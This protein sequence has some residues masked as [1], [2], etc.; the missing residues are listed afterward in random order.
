MVLSTVKVH[1]VLVVPDSQVGVLRI[2]NAS[3]SSPLDNIKLKKTGFH[4]LHVLHSPPA[5]KGM[6]GNLF[7]YSFR[8]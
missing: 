5:K 1:L 7:F 4:A 3:R 8:V 2:W 6:I